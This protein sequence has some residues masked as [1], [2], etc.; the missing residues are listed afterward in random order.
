MP[1]LGR[2]TPTQ[3]RLSL[4]PH[5]VHI[6]VPILPPVSASVSL[7]SPCPTVCEPSRGAES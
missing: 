1:A 2:W 7:L 6:P 3:V 4:T 5:P